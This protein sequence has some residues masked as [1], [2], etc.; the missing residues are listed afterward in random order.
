MRVLAISALPAL[1]V[2]AE[3]LNIGSGVRIDASPRSFKALRDQNV[4]RQKL[5]YSCGAAALST[6]LTYG[7]GIPVSER[8]LL[9]DLFVQLST[10]EIDVREKSGV[11]LLDLQRLAQARGLRA[12]G[13]RI[14]PEALAQ[15]SAPVIV[16]I[17]PEGY[18]H[19]VVFRGISG[20][21]VFLADPSRGNVR[22]PAYRFLENWLD[23]SGTGV[24][25]AVES[26]G[27]PTQAATSALAIAPGTPSQ[28]ELMSARELL[29]VGTAS[30]QPFR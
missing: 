29:A 2:A 26:P 19:F 30:R 5:D 23:E 18:K 10:D 16:F 6:L 24:I 21:R 7:I 1:P 9:D 12:Q 27:A 8:E 17:Q 22:M 4:V 15:L 14:G 11:S 28:P 25:F 13:F 20:D 3:P